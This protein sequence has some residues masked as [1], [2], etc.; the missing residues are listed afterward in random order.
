MMEGLSGWCSTMRAGIKQSAWIGTIS[1]HS[2]SLLT[3]P[4]SIPSSGS[5]STSKATFCQGSSPKMAKNSQTNLNSQFGRYSIRRRQFNRCAGPIVNNGRQFWQ[6]VYVAQRKPNPTRAYLSEASAAI[7][8]A[9]PVFTGDPSFR[10]KLPRTD[11]QGVTIDY[12][13]PERGIVL[14]GKLETNHDVHRIVVIDDRDDKPGAY[15]VKGYVTKTDKASRFSV[16]IPRPR[17]CSGTL[18]LLVV[19][20]NGAVSGGN[21]KSGIGSAKLVPYSFP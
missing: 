13:P 2:S 20:T 15:W 8:S 1:E 16:T 17:K 18:K 11:F 12:E 10:N 21:L 6:W 7:L 9:H 14:K 5:G 3:V 4:T 19:Y